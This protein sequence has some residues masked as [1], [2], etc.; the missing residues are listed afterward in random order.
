MN[1]EVE[2]Y[3]EVNPL[4]WLSIDEDYFNLNKFAGEGNIG[5]MVE[6]VRTYGMG[7]KQPESP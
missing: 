3:E 4:E 1:E 7:E 2:L 5:H 6:Q